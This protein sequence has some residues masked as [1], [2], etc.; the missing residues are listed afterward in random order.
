MKLSLSTGRW[1]PTVCTALLCAGV[2]PLAAADLGR[3]S[4]GAMNPQ[5]DTA[6]R[7][8]YGGDVSPAEWTYPVCSELP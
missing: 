2:L 8:L 3:L 6:G 4:W 1:K 7:T 5:N